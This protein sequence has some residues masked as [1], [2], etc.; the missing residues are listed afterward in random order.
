V[1]RVWFES[2]ILTDAARDAEGSRHAGG[3]RRPR[4]HP[5]AGRGLTGGR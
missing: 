4:I 2:G 5:P 3:V 1:P